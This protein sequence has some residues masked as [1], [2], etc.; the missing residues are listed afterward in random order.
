MS[1]PIIIIDSS[2]YTGKTTLANSLMNEYRNHVY[3]HCGVC[4][5]IYSLHTT[6]LYN[7]VNL[8]KEF[9]VIIDRLHYSELVYGTVF[10]NGS[11]YNVYEFDKHMN[12][13]D[14][15]Y[16]VM[17]LPPK[18][19][20]MNGFKNRAKNG[21]EMFDTVEKVYD[22]YA[23]NPLGWKTYDW[24]KGEKFDLKNYKVK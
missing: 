4:P 1:W 11:S 18:D 7:A 5:D 21:G 20:V 9:T 13:I 23:E 24:T 12:G 6:A 10:R 16:K 2:D 17:C 19:I 15:L 14:N 8:S 22:M 3:I